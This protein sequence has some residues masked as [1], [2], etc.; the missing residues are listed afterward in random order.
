MWGIRLSE[1]LVRELGKLRAFDRKRLL[2]AIARALRHEPDAPSKSR[3]LLRNLTPPFEAVPPVWQLRVGEYRV[4]YDVERAGRTVY[5]RAV[6][7]KPPHKT[8][9]EIL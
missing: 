2:D 9:G 3:K 8:T 5:V 1:G 4:F 6:R 7:R